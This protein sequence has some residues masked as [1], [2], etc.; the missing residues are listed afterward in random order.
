MAVNFSK[1][2]I[3]EWEIVDKDPYPKKRGEPCKAK[4]SLGQRYITI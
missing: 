1:G 3:V 4:K 2:D